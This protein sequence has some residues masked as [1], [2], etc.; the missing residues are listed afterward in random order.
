MSYTRTQLKQA[1][2][3]K[4]DPTEEFKPHPVAMTLTLAALLGIM[5]GISAGA[6]ALA[7]LAL[8]FISLPPLIAGGIIGSAVIL[9]S[10]IIDSCRS[11]K[12]TSLNDISEDMSEEHKRVLR[13]YYNSTECKVKNYVNIITNIGVSFGI[14]AGLVALVFTSPAAIG[15]LTFVV[16]LIACIPLNF[17]IDKAIECFFPEGSKQPDSLVDSDVEVDVAVT[18]LNPCPTN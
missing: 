3:A 10:L 15:A 16:S 6:G 4:S 14:G 11:Q 2:Q 1:L 17:L 5:A 9:I 18:G 13:E 7:G 12:T 8:S